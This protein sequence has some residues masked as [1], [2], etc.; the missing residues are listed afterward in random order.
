MIKNFGL[1]EFQK[2]FKKDFKVT[3]NEEKKLKDISEIFKVECD[4]TQA[5]K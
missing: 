5:S 2:E 4:K 1:K 3:K